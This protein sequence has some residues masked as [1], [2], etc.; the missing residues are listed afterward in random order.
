MPRMKTLLLLAT[1]TFAACSSQPKTGTVTRSDQTADETTT[2]DPTTGD[3][4]KPA[5]GMGETCGT[6]DTCAD[7]LACV[8][9]YGIAGPSGPAFKSC[10]VAC[11][12][13]PSVC[14]EGTQCISI[15]DGPGQVCRPMEAAE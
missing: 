12:D 7:G 10:E 3:E 11:A 15:A 13:D 6:D 4:S 14:P 2:D 9:Y 5:P 8:T 1:V